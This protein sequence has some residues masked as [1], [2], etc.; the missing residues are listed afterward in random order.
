MQQQQPP[1]IPL[2]DGMQV[3]EGYKLEGE[4]ET[5]NREGR[6]FQLM[7]DFDKHPIFNKLIESADVSELRRIVAKIVSQPESLIKAS[8]NP[9][10]IKSVRKLI[11]VLGKTGLVSDMNTAICTGNGFYRLMIHPIGSSVIFRCLDVASSEHNK[12]LYEAAITYCLELAKHER[13]CTNLK[14]FITSCR[15]QGRQQLLDFIAEHS[16]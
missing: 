3:F 7:N 8:L 5:V 12:L 2:L 16:L 11:K 14:K 4:R 10:G 6:V 15:G 1:E 13:G 9:H